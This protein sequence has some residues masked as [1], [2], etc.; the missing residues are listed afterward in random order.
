M[1]AITNS[2]ADDFVAAPPARY[3]ILLLFGSDR[4][5]VAER[6]ALA[7]RHF[8]G[9]A[10]GQKIQ[11]SGDA[12]AAEP[13]VLVDEANSIDM[14]DRAQRVICVS[15]GGKSILPALE[16]IAKAPPQNCLI[17]LEAGDLRRDAPLRKWVE[18]QAFAASIECR[19]DEPRSLLR[20]VEK[21]LAAAGREIEP[22]ARDALLG[23]L[24]EDRIATRN[25]IEKLLLFTHGQDEIRLSDVQAICYD[26]NLSQMDAVIDG[27]FSRE[28]SAMLDLLLGAHLSGADPT[29][30]LLA[31]MRHVLAMHRSFG[32][33]NVNDALQTFLRGTG[34]YSRKAELTRQLKSV[35]P[36]EALELIRTLQGFTQA[37][38]QSPTLFNQRLVRLLLSRSNRRDRAAR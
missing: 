12:V 7:S 24:G 3:F 21:E 25:E 38:R 26:P 16:M 35:A 33:N 4:G 23:V 13:L 22:S 5:L 34:G 31:M 19:P 14:F 18:A 6:L 37:T 30:L 28:R 29:A 2:E 32:L 36:G 9:E 17:L 15:V 1:V 27:F 10:R 11:L 8:M 20:L